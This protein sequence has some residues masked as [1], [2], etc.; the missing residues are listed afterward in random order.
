MRGDT[1]NA[2]CRRK[3]G[4]LSMV[5]QVCELNGI[6]NPNNIEVGQTILLP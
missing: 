3:Y 2:I 5:K 4:D 1:L 6:K